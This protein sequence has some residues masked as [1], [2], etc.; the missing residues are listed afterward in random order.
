VTSSLVQ[1]LRR[2]RYAHLYRRGEVDA[3]VRFLPWA[4]ML[5]PG[6]RRSAIRIGPNSTIGGELFTF[7]HG[8]QISIGAWCFVGEGTRIWSASQVRVGDRVLIS[9]GVNIHDTNAHPVD[10]AARHQHF[11]AISTTGH[12]PAIDSIVSAPVDIGD[13]AWIGFGSIILK[14][15]RIGARAIIGAGSVVTHDVPDD[16]VHIGTQLRRDVTA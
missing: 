8:G 7:A 14:G 12:P 4:R 3:S 11:V 1:A 13:D 2:V 15:V 10:P 16:G 5:N 6:G 9:H